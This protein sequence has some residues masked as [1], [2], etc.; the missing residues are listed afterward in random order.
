MDQRFP[1][2]NAFRFQPFGD[3]IVFP[4]VWKLTRVGEMLLISAEVEFPIPLL[5]SLPNRNLDGSG[6]W[7]GPRFDY[8]SEGGWL[9]V[10]NVLIG[11][12]LHGR[13]DL[14]KLWGN[15]FSKSQGLVSG[16]CS[17]LPAHKLSYM[18]TAS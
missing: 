17:R 9:D 6:F 15:W 3:E 8:L 12:D 16:N 11:T 2:N 18:L 14:E 7:S 1:T 13:C 10:R 5:Q 4:T